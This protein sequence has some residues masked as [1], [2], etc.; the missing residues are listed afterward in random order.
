MACHLPKE[1]W[2]PFTVQ[3][4]HPAQNNRCYWDVSSFGPTCSAFLPD[5]ECSFWVPSARATLRCWLSKQ[6]IIK[7]E[8]TTVLCCHDMDHSCFIKPACPALIR[9][10]SCWRVQRQILATAAVRIRYI[11]Q[12]HQRKERNLADAR[13]FLTAAVGPEIIQRLAALPAHELVRRIAF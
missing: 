4:K 11:S 1:L 8:V 13:Y 3:V 7:F 5:F 10:A 9:T 12:Q 2:I 6:T